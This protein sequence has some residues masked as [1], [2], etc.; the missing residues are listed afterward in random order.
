[1]IEHSSGSH[2]TCLIS[3]YGAAPELYQEITFRRQ[4]LNRTHVAVHTGLQCSRAREI[5]GLW[6]KI[7]TPWTCTPPDKQPSPPGL[8]SCEQLQRL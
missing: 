6:F 3:T 2:I 5:A 8:P 7:G 1:M 4:A